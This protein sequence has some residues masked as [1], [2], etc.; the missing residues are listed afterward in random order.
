MHF[1]R[2]VLVVV[3]LGLLILFTLANWNT[4]I[5][6]T[7]LSLVV[8]EVEAPFGLVMLGFSAVLAAALLWYAL[9][10]QIG[11]LTESRRQAEEL[12]RHRELADQAEASRF[13]D[14]KQYLERELAALRQAQQDSEQRLRDELAATTNTL[15]AC[16]GELDDR[17]ERQAPTSP[18]QMP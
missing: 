16:I 8:T 6:P 2:V 11:A 4:F 7:R 1:S 17:L 18:E 12:R 10:V 13:T 9:R 5:A 14:L 15:S 3:V